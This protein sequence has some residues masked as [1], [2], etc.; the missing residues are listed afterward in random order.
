MNHVIPT[1]RMRARCPSGGMDGR[2]KLFPMDPRTVQFSSLAGEESIRGGT[3]SAIAASL[4]SQTEGPPCLRFVR[5]L[6]LQ[7]DQS[8][9][10]FVDRLIAAGQFVL[11]G[12]EKDFRDD[13]EPVALGVIDSVEGHRHAVQGGCP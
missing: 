2:R 12:F 7:L 13:L 10:H 5:K 8:V 9:L 11:R 6:I 3:A 1:G 4:H